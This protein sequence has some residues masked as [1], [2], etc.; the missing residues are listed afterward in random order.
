[1]PIKPSSWGVALTTKDYKLH[2]E[3]DLGPTDAPQPLTGHGMTSPNQEISDP[4]TYADVIMKNGRQTAVIRTIRPGQVTSVTYTVTYPPKA[5]WTPALALAQSGGRCQK[6][7]Y[8]IPD[9]ISERQYRHWKIWPQA[10]LNPPVPAGDLITSNEEDEVI[11]YTSELSSGEELTGWEIGANLKYTIPAT[12]RANTVAFFTEDCVDCDTTLGL[13]M[14]VG[15][16]DGV[17][18]PTTLTTEDRFASVTS[19]SYGAATD[20]VKDI[21]TSG[22]IGVSGLYT[23]VSFAA[24]TA[25]KVFVSA[26]GFATTPVEYAGITDVPARIVGDGRTVFLVGKDATGN[27]I[28][29]YSLD[30][31]SSWTESTSSALPTGSALLDASWDVETQRLYVVGEDGTLLLGTFAGSSL[32]LV[33]ISANLPG[34]PGDI[35]TVV[36]MGKNHV[37]VG[38]A[39]GYGAQS[40]DDGATFSTLTVA[41]STAIVSADGTTD[42]L[43]VAAGSNLYVRDPLRENAFKV[44]TVEDGLSIS[45]TYTSVRMGPNR[46]FNLFAAGTS[47]GNV[48]ILKDFRPE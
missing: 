16:G 39:A 17:A 13:A 30:G 47:G 41:G 29:W 31:G 21:Y 28:L 2:M 23:G 7:F 38:G 25:G 27:G 9:C 5:L 24:A 37:F 43:V 15:G 36:A 11:A 22:D 34:S 14:I 45:G 44:L 10:L 46:N 4:L 1:M 8:G 19:V 20:V 18:A 48:V 33:D 26:D 12:K 3:G 35:A 32:T 42:R 6:D 40:R